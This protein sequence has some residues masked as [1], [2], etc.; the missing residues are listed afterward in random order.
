[1]NTEKEKPSQDKE[2][3]QDEEKNLNQTKQKKN[4][5]PSSKT[6][7]TDQYYI[8]L[9]DKSRI[10]TI[11]FRIFFS[12]LFIISFFLKALT[13]KH[14]TFWQSFYYLT[15]INLF[16]SGISLG[17]GA[18][19][20]LKP[21]KIESKWTK[22]YG[23]LHSTFYTS[24]GI[25]SIF[26]WIVVAKADFA[27]YSNPEKCPSYGFCLYYT[28]IAHLFI[29]FPSWFSLFTERMNL[30]WSKILYPFI[31]ASIYFPWLIL[32]SLTVQK[33]YPGMSFKDVGSYVFSAA[34]YGLLVLSFYIGMK[35]S[36]WKM[37][38]LKKA[39]GKTKNQ[40][41]EIKG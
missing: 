2:I 20:A 35:I 21:R 7:L 26:Y 9:K 29:L 12:I 25:V 4:P 27:T 5:I 22:F 30:T 17:I 34:A 15:H 8:F 41:G 3:I 16:L 6:E 39:E 24:G 32:V 31:F 13:A 14:R 19:Y 28:L 1:M 18:I 40:V 33:I 23:I 38:K 11:T 37:R 36:Q 10:K